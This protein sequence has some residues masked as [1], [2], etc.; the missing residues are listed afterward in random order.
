MFET[1]VGHGTSIFRDRGIYLSRNRFTRNIR[2][3]TLPLFTVIVL[4]S[5]NAR[6][7]CLDPAYQYAAVHDPRY[8]QAQSEYDAAR[9]KF[10]QARALML[11][12]ATA[13]LEW[14]ATARTQTCSAST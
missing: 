7:F 9:Q 10:P 5:G 2:S 4:S 14:G 1:R 11:P 3:A 13:Q 8:L 6:A 12:Q